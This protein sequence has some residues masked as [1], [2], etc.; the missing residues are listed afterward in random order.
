MLSWRGQGQLT[1]S[2][3]KVTFKVIQPSET[4]GMQ[5]LY[6]MSFDKNWPGSLSRVG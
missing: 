2:L 5:F 4:T 3:R 1:C 6:R